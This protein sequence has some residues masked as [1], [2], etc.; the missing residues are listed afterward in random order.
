MAPDLAPLLFD[1][2]ITAGNGGNGGFSY[3]NAGNG[4][5]SYAVF[6]ADIKDGATPEVD[7]SNTLTA[8]SG[9]KAGTTS[10]G[11]KAGIAGSAAAT[12]F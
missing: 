12:N 1:N 9:G 6:D 10:T 3:G 4:G 11:G 5:T 8:G 7:L 2:T